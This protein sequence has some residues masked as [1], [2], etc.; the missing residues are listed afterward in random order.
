MHG[1]RGVAL[2]EAR[3]HAAHRLDGQAEGRHIEQKDAVVGF[4]QAR[5]R[6]GK[7]GRLQS[8]SHG[9]A[10]VRVDGRGRLLA[11][12]PTHVLL[13]GGD[14]RGAAHQKHAPQ[15]GRGDA[16]VV[17]GGLH[18]P[19][20]ALH[21]IARH[22]VERGARERCFEMRG[23]RGALRQKRK[24]DL[25]GFERRELLFRLARRLGHA[26]Q[27]H[28]V[29]PHVDAVLALERIEQIRDH[30]LVEVVAA[31]VV[32]A[33]RRQHL[34]DVVADLDD[35]HVERA[36]AQVVHHH[37]LRLPVVQPVRERGG[38]G[39]VDDAQHV[40]AGDAPGVL[41]G[42]ALRVIEVRGNRD[43]GLRD[44]LIEKRLGVASE[45]A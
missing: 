30:A 25:R 20:G 16:R 10:F 14:A 24:V 45:L 22:V 31:Q 40:E 35:G 4:H 21:Q 39:L 15:L 13:H 7:R 41:R 43:D 29:A 9:H 23:T 1:Q 32:V 28:L 18:G 38:R 19:R 27:R 6:A 5:R 2:D 3:G 37:L 12:E 8:G 17:E 44:L 26:S 42:L 34:D 33:R 36:A 11:R